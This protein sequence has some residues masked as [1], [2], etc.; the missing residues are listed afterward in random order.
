[1]PSIITERL[2]RTGAFVECDLVGRSLKAQMKYANKIGARFSMVLG[3]DEIAN[4]SAKLKNMENGEQSEIPL[5]GEQFV[6]ELTAA[7]LEAQFAE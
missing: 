5:D 3:D 2:R 4:G 6:K 7:K 1:M